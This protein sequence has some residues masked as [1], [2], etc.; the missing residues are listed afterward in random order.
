M[1]ILGI[2][3][4]G[5]K[6]TSVL[7]TRGGDVLHRSSVTL[8]K[9]KGSEVGALITEQIIQMVD[10]SLS[11][12]EKI[13][14]VG[15]SVPGIS[16]SETGT[17]WAPNIPGWDNYPLLGEIRAITGDIPVTIDNDRACYILGEFWKGNARSCSHAIFIAVGTG[18]GA[19]ILADGKVLRGNN[20]IAGSVGWM[21]L[22]RPFKENYIDC[23]C[24]EYHAS[25][26]GIAK[27]ALEYLGKDKSY[28]GELRNKISKELSSHDVM[29]AY[30]NGDI[31]AKKVVAEAIKFWGMAAAN[32]VSI[33]NPEKI[34]FGGGLFGPAIPLLPDIK[35][36]AEK[37][38]QPVSIN[39]VTF[40]TSALAGDAGVYG[41]AYL[42]LKSLPGEYRHKK[43]V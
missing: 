12:E 10:L 31:L 7:F 9:R 2:D 43:D 8:D 4:G 23:G 37:W 33:F 15:I 39:H 6:I 13:K 24:F 16:Y 25:G 28:G 11:E 38:A 36:E 34:I 35:K 3:L 20:D 41:A 30:K 5:T 14:S 1:A 22:N 42:A 17:V 19:G 27:V 26:A 21:A 29:R 18:I 32:L 40:D